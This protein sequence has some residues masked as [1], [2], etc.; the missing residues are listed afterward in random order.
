[1]T[2]YKFYERGAT[3]YIKIQNDGTEALEEYYNNGDDWT[4]EEV[5]RDLDR[6]G[7]TGNGIYF[8]AE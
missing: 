3:E 6:T 2:Y 7:A 5:Q 1:M 4:P 8:V